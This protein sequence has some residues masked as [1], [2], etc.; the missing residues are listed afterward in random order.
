MIFKVLLFLSQLLS[1]LSWQLLNVPT[2]FGSY[3]NKRHFVYCLV[4]INVMR[5]LKTGRQK[6]GSDTNLTIYFISFPHKSG[7][8]V[9][10]IVQKTSANTG[11]S[12]NFIYTVYSTYCKY[13]A[14]SAKFWSVLH[15][16]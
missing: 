12:S 4:K 1:I 15:F 7:P 14:K 3:N 11:K 10:N 8:N 16:S 13:Q 6:K 9:T 2:S 5:T